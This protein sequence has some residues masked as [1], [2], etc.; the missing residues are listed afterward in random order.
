MHGQFAQGI[1]GKLQFHALHRHELGKLLGES[2]F[3]FSQHR[4]QLVFGQFVQHRHHRQ[5]AD[6]FRNETVAEQVLRLDKLQ[7]LATIHCR[8]LVRLMN[9][10]ETHHPMTKPALNHFLQTNKRAA[11][12]KQNVG[13]IDADVILLRV[14]AAALRRHIAH[15]ALQNFQQRLL[16]AFSRNVA[17]DGN[18]F[19]FP[20]DLVNLVDVNDAH[21]GSFHVVISVLEQ[22]QNDVL[23]VFA[24]VAGFGQGRGIGNGKGNVE[25]LCQRAG[26][27]R[28]A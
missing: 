5:A 17:G 10:A 14:L 9:R 24:D 21:L 25:N 22:A 26:E 15:G 28:L 27:Q 8:R 3:R 11:A 20:R 18:V 16:H 12:D 2:M 4:H 7:N 13:R 19:R 1:S 6:E 23:D